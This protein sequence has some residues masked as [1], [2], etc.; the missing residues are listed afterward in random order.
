MS[1]IIRPLLRALAGTLLL[2]GTACAETAP[3]VLQG[4]APGRWTMDLD[5]AVAK[6]SEKQLPILMNFTGSDW[7]GWCKLMQKQVF[8]QKEW[9]DYAT[10]HLLLVWIDSPKDPSLVP[11]RFVQRNE[12]LAR[13]Y[14]IRGPPT[15]IILDDDGKTVLGQLGATPNA[16]AKSFIEE[17]ERACRYRPKAVEEFAKALSP[18]EAQAY[19]KLAGETLAARMKLQPL[20]DGD[21]PE[22]RAAAESAASLED[23]VERWHIDA[24]AKALGP[25]KGPSYKKLRTARL[26][27]EREFETWLATRPLRTPE[28]AK[29]FK[30]YQD[31]LKALQAEIEKF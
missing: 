5:A 1:H 24:E 11:A 25:E 20:A 26:T 8:S 6:A 19:R 17:V 9:S 12:E 23:A 10:G 14:E 21:S 31:R 18:A 22:R 15:Y 27:V 3:I 7:C 4:A 13:K 28:N 29:V 2:A 30:A 16:T